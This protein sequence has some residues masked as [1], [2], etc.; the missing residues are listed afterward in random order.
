MLKQFSWIG[1]GA[2]SVTLG[3][4]AVRSHRQIDQPVGPHL[5]TAI[6]GT[7]FRLNK[8]SDLPNAAGNRDI[9]GGKIDRG[10]AEI[11]LAGI[12]QDTLIIDVVDFNRQS[13]ETT[14]DRYK[15]FQQAGV[16]NVDVQQ[17]VSSGTTQTIAPS[18]IRLDTRKQREIV[19]SGVKVIFLE[20]HLYSV[21]YWLQDLQPN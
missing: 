12:E 3:C 2:L 16:V 11:K 10:F 1:I 20:V 15:A 9:L 21:S 13:A 14:M 17:S 18:R 5:T 6:G 19:I 8:S 7:I 4:G